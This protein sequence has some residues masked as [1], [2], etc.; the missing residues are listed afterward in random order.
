MGNT[1]FSVTCFYAPWEDLITHAPA[2]LIWNI[3]Y[4]STLRVRV[5]LQGSGKANKQGRLDIK[6]ITKLE[7]YF[8]SLDKDIDTEVLSYHN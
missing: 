2:S 5:Y 3:I 8:S 7:F 1:E 6:I 4:L